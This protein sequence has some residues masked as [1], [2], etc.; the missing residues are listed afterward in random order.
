[1]CW[2]SLDSSILCSISKWHKSIGLT[3]VPPASHHLVVHS[4]LVCGRRLSP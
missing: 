2:A 3:Y 4:Q 1:M